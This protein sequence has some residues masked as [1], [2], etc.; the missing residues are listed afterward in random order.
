[1]KIKMLKTLSGKEGM[2]YK[3]R[4]VE[5]EDGYAR[6]LIKKG[7]A[8]EHIRENNIEDI[9]YEAKVD[10]PEETKLDD[11]TV[12]ELKEKAKDRDIVGYSSMRKQEL[13]DKLEGK[14]IEGKS[15]DEVKKLDDLPKKAK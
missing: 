14:V 15:L 8:V 10:I 12:S 3:S 5:V 2:L 7:L 9:E 4:L 1:M 6:E 11:L 13:I